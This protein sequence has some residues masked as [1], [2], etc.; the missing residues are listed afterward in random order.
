[1]PDQHRAFFAG[2]PLLFLGVRDTDGQP[3]ATVVQGAPGFIQSPE[4][5]LLQVSALP[6]PRI[7]R[8]TRFKL[9][10]ALGRWAWSPL[11]GAETG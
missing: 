4:P 5:R 9:A 6:L 11:P 3:W 7:R 2:L 10:E 8:S 1:M